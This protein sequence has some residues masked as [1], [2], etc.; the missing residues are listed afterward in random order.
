MVLTRMN[1]DGFLDLAELNNFIVVYPQGLVYP[2]KNSTGWNTGPGQD[3]NNDLL[4]FES[5]IDLLSRDFNIN[6]DKVYVTG[7]SMGG[8]MS[9]DIACSPL[10]QKIAAV[11]PVSGKNVFGYF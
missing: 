11:A 10:S 1:Y 6:L 5:M 9:Y 2:E 4:F 7:F 3:I 8:F